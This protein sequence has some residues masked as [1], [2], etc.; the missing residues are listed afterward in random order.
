ML[1]PGLSRLSFP[2]A[3]LLLSPSS[4]TATAAPPP[5]FPA[6]PQD[7]PFASLPGPCAFSRASRRAPGVSKW[8]FGESRLGRSCLG[9]P[10]EATP[11]KR[12]GKGSWGKRQGDPLA[13]FRLSL[14]EQNGPGPLF[15]LSALS[16]QG[17][18]PASPARSLGWRRWGRRDYQAHRSKTPSPS[19]L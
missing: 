8:S 17:R 13:A 7:L 1:G 15:W 10:D 4:A 12:G 5:S 3:L 19:W 16:P 6:S 18:N 11:E 14:C 9:C 2:Q